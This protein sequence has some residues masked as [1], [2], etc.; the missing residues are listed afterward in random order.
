MG[1]IM[2]PGQYFLNAYFAEHGACLPTLIEQII[3]E[4]YTRVL[5]PDGVAIDG[6]ANIG[7]HTMAMAKVAPRGR[8]HAFEPIPEVF[9]DL[10]RNTAAF[11]NVTRHNH[12]ISNRAGQAEFTVFDDPGY[13]GLVARPDQVNEQGSRKIQVQVKT[14]DELK[15]GLE[16]LDFVKLDLE[17]AEYFAILGAEKTFTRHR[18]VIALE[19]GAQL[20]ADMYGYRLDDMFD[21]FEERSYALYDIAGTPFLSRDEYARAQFYRP[22]SSVAIPRE[23]PADVL[24]AAINAA[25]VQML[26]LE[27]HRQQQG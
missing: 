13:S 10:E 16:R 7:F 12:A 4:L 25:C 20:A 18:P 3:L 27:R 15:L 17:G 6:G 22:W 2:F 26:L 5:P 19:D 11:G 14:I 8:V 1:E 21:F 9:R 24:F 23:K